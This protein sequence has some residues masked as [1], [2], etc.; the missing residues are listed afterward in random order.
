MKAEDDDAD[1][2]TDSQRCLANSREKPTPYQLPQASQVWLRDDLC[3]DPHGTDPPPAAVWNLPFAIG[4]RLSL[5][6]QKR[7]VNQNEPRLVP[8][9]G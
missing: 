6:S 1:E 3:T 4:R 8:L 5:L 9:V 2:F 7:G